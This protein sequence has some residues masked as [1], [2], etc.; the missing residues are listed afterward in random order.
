M[1]SESNQHKAAL[2]VESTYFYNT[3][4]KQNQISGCQKSSEERG[5]TTRCY[6][7]IFWD[8]GYTL[9]SNYDG[10]NT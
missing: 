7:G 5:M 3:L 6:M 10:G 9:Y 4:E 2:S 8:D 1:L